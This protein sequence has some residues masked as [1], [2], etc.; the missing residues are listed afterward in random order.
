M[1]TARLALAYPWRGSIR[2][3]YKTRPNTLI[4][5][6]H[7]DLA[8]RAAGQPYITPYI[9]PRNTPGQHACV[10]AQAHHT[11]KMQK[12]GETQH[13]ASQNVSNHTTPARM[14]ACPPGQARPAFEHTQVAG[15]ERRCAAGVTLLYH[16]ATG[17]LLPQQF[18]GVAARHCHECTATAACS[19]TVAQTVAQ[20]V[21][22][23]AAAVGAGQLGP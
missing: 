11:L 15:R 23:M 12:G 16:T 5:Q 14:D 20:S 21:A 3:R 9:T 2:C 8:T 6:G 17:C 1:N 7:N 22:G 4:V 18:W 10:P 13:S 19:Q